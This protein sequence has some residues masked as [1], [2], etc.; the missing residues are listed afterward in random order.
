MDYRIHTNTMKSFVPSH[1]VNEDR[2]LFTEF[3][4]M[5]DKKIRLMII[6]DGMGGLEDGQIAAQN[7]VTGFVEAF[8]QEIMNCYMD[9]DMDGFSLKYAVHDVEDAMIRALQS[10]N[11]RVCENADYM[12]PT[13]STLSAVCI[14][15]DFAIVI[16]VGDSPVY[17]YRDAKK[18]MKLVSVL[19]TKAEQDVFKG[20]YERYS[21]EYYANDH[22]I[23]CSLGQYGDLAPED[24][25]VTSIG[26]LKPGDLF[27][28]GSDGAFGRM[29]EAEI[30]ELLEYCADGAEGFILAKLFDRAREDKY[31]DQTAILYICAE[32]KEGR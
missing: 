23:Y 2:Y 20:L 11:D 29:S 16:N 3:S 10:A 28:L 30:K 6:A 9:T 15:E 5:E 21:E 32:E 18:Q 31:D 27:L 1:K 19:Q 25:C 12:K 24:I 8:Y 26:K 4:F 17:F 13:G 14:F 7:G 22:R